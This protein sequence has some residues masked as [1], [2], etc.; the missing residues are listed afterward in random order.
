MAGM[1]MLKTAFLK[2]K[3]QKTKTFLALASFEQ[4]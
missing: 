3:K 4:E 1:K 2:E